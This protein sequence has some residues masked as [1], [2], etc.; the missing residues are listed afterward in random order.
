MAIAGAATPPDVRRG[1]APPERP[2]SFMTRRRG[3]AP[4]HIGRQSRGEELANYLP[5]AEWDGVTKT[6]GGPD[7]CIADARFGDRV[8]G[9]GNDLEF[10]LRPG[11]VQVPR[12]QERTNDVVTSM[13]DHRR[14]VTYAI[15]VLDQIVISFEE[16]VVDEVV[17]L[18]TRHRDRHLGFR[19]LV[20]Q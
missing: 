20:D 12:I 13:H 15:D 2:S 5:S 18:D 11:F 4:P 3:E 10:R 17:T 16:A 6:V 9:V 19:K 7:E 8:A 14:N 1:F